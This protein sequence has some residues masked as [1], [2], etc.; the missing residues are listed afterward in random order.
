MAGKENWGPM[1][2]EKPIFSLDEHGH[3]TLTWCRGT[4]FAHPIRKNSEGG[5]EADLSSYLP[6]DEKVIRAK[7]NAKDF[8]PGEDP[9]R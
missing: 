3:F 1:G 6:I 9:Y 8:T 7:I 2:A 5:W 4:P